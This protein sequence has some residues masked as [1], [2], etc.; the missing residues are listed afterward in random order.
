MHRVVNTESYLRGEKGS[1]HDEANYGHQFEFQ[2][3]DI[4]SSFFDAH[5]TE[6][7]YPAMVLQWI[8]FRQATSGIYICAQALHRTIVQQKKIIVPWTSVDNDIHFVRIDEHLET[9]R[10]CHSV[11][12]VSSLQHP[13]RHKKSLTFKYI[14]IYIAWSVLTEDER[15]RWI[16]NIKISHLS[17]RS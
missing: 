7:V 17:R 10:I 8:L 1:L 3:C 9:A 4:L 12:P 5:Q 13:L 16:Y 6:S 14:Y 15:Q 2:T 11:K